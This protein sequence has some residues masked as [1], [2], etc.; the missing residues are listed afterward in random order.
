LWRLFHGSF[1][2]SFTLWC[3]DDVVVVGLFVCLLSEKENNN[4]ARNLYKSMIFSIRSIGI[5]QN[6]DSNCLCV[7][8]FC[9][10]R[11]SDG[12]THT[13]HRTEG[14]TTKDEYFEVHDNMMESTA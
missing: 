2:R 7:R 4:L 11:K 5:N 9:I 1:V 12:A 6:T 14:Q 13:S 10:F 3:V 8:F